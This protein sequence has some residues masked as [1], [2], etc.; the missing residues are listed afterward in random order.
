MV[1]LTA[2]QQQVLDILRTN[3]TDK[4]KLIVIGNL[5]KISKQFHYLPVSSENLAYWIN[6][7]FPDK[8][9]TVD[10]DETL[11]GLLDFPCDTLDLTQALNDL[12]G[13]VYI[14]VPKDVTEID[15]LNIHRAINIC[16]NL[17][18]VEFYLY[19]ENQTPQ[20]LFVISE[21]SF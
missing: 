14:R 7:T 9:W 4:D 21:V 3:K 2:F 17:N 10:G 5:L 16:Q 15:Q 1:N 6:E 8:L 12:Y 19:R 20:D 11:S 18:V 13:I